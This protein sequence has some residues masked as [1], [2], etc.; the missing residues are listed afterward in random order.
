MSQKTN[1][2]GQGAGPIAVTGASGFIGTHLIQNLHASGFSTRALVRAKRGRTLDLPDNTEL[3][4]GSLS[5]GGALD[6]LL[7]EAKTCVHLAGATK[8]IDVA[9]FHR[10]NAIGTFRLAS[11]AVAH[12]VEHF[13]H[14]SSQAARAPSLSDYAASKAAS[15][16]ALAPFH[17]KM[18]ITIIR[19]P[20]VIGPGDPMLQP[21][22]DLIKAGWLP[23]PTEP[24][25]GTRR[26]AV[27]SVRDLVAQISET[28]R[29]PNTPT[30]LIEPSSLTAATWAEM[31]AAASEVR[32]KRVRTLRVWPG[33]L[34]ALGVTADAISSI[35]RRPMPVSYGKIRE[36]LAADWTY[37][38]AVQNAMTLE[39]ILATCLCEAS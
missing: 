38:S 35:V 7:A 1:A 8:S 25:A 21:M 22:F 39:E 29:H 26:F 23:A 13:V 9:G 12:G 10:A 4:S 33:L 2:E 3:V 34:I 14:V 19:P 31:A 5:D 17:A 24:R 6:Q 37:D 11:K 15:E 16:R 20:A 27:I 32:G 18:K 30:S 36:M 28:V